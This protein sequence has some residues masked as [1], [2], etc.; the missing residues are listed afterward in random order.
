ML[1]RALTLLF[2]GLNLATVTQ[3]QRSPKAIADSITVTADSSFSRHGFARWL[4]GDTY[5][6][7][8]TTPVRVEVLDLDRFAGGLLP[9]ERGGGLQT[10]SLRFKGANGKEYQFRLVRKDPNQVVGPFNNTFVGDIV[11]DQMSAIHPGGALVVPVLSKAAGVLN[12][13]PL[14]RF[15]PDHPRLG[16]YRSE[17]GNQLGTIEERPA[18]GQNGTGFARSSKIE[19]TEAMLNALREQPWIGVDSRTYL[20]ARLL[21]LVIGDWDRHE[22]QYRWALVGEGDRARWQP[23]PRDRDQAFVRYDGALLSV[24]RVALPKLLVYD[25]AHSSPEAATFNGRHLDRRLLNT[26]GWPAWDSV[27]RQ[28]QSRLTD[29]VID[30]AVHQLP[31][32]YESQN[33]ERLRQVLKARRDELRQ[34]SQAFYLYLANPVFLYAGDQEDW[35]DILRQPAGRTEIRMG[36]V[37]HNAPYYDRIFTEKETQEIR[38]YLWG[39]ADR[40]RVLGQGD[41]P[42]VRV[43]T[44]DGR[45]TVEHSEKANGVLVYDDDGA[46]QADGLAVDTKPYVTVADTSADSESDVPPEQDWGRS[47]SPS[48]LLHASAH[49]GF[50]LG[51]KV[52]LFG[53]G[54]RRLPYSSRNTASLE[55]SFR[56]TALRFENDNRWR[57][58]NRNTYLGFSLMVSGIEGGRFFGFGDTTTLATVDSRYVVLR[59]EYEISP[60]IGFGLESP[61]RL[62]LM[63]RARQTSTDL[64]DPN[65]RVSMVNQLKP[66]GTGDVGQVGPAVRFEY[67][68]RD[69]Q[70]AATRGFYV[71]VDGDYY[72]ITW[73]NGGKP[74]G[75]IEG[76]AATYLSPP[77]APQRLTLALRAG[78]RQVWGDYPYFEA[79]YL[80]GKRSLR[81]YYNDRWA[82]DRSVFG[83][84]EVRLKLFDSRLIIPTEVGLLG[85]ADAGRIWYQDDPAGAW[86]TN[87][88]GGMWIS[89]PDR[90]GGLS[91]GVGRGSEGSR[92][93]ILWGTPF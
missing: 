71:R 91:L 36:R 80:G 58:V 84:A 7:L 27:T 37:G 86:H 66:P 43:I 10:H 77:F 61:A 16:E 19:G 81:G 5:R 50:S 88:G 3:A 35:V 15:M 63:V 92:F 11:R 69:V 26:L 93:W 75:S 17:F 45:D 21:D 76:T 59:D 29:S 70:M 31:P 60:Y 87:F 57:M 12:E 42:K 65:N 38:I 73:A 89:L 25:P 14:L 41:R 83:N 49:A 90:T 6:E 20:T 55:Y 1:A 24:A 78:G 74:F 82:G 46:V 68:S 54:F 28:L 30:Q 9:L 48:P 4:L 40:V 32:E 34:A 79:A 53:H 64:T 39:G 13:A 52:S 22:D 23:I 8:W 47:V 72:P 51:M 18:E 62:F 56:R 85:L 2:F 33:G 44:G 67:D